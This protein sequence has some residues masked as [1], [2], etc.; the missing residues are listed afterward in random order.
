MSRRQVNR[1]VPDI[2]PGCFSRR[3]RRAGLKPTRVSEISRATGPAEGASARSPAQL[4]ILLWRKVNCALANQ[5]KVGVVGPRG[6]GARSIPPLS[7]IESHPPWGHRPAL[8]QTN[9]GLK[10]KLSSLLLLCIRHWPACLLPINIGLHPLLGGSLLLLS[11][12]SSPTLAS[13]RSD[14]LLARS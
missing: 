3:E 14:R 6:P 9:R 8:V 7:Q 12:I 2:Y 4:A 5:R 1:P 10:P 11:L 13:A